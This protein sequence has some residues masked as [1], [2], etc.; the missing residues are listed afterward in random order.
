MAT[1]LYGCWLPRFFFLGLSETQTV[2]FTQ[3][4]DMSQ[5]DTQAESDNIANTP[6]IPKAIACNHYF[7][8]IIITLTSGITLFLPFF[9]V[10]SPKHGT[11][12]S[13]F[14]LP[15]FI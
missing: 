7:S 13:N 10:L 12:S 9:I 8:K 15:V 2:K 11:L 14:F 4:D 5:S 1:V 6:E 3:L